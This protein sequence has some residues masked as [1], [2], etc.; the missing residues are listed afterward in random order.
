M[1]VDTR[2]RAR[3]ARGLRVGTWVPVGPVRAEPVV[4]AGARLHGVALSAQRRVAL[5]AQTCFRTVDRGGTRDTGGW[6]RLNRQGSAALSAEGLDEARELA[7]QARVRGVGVTGPNGLSKGVA[8]PLLEASPD[9]EM[10]GGLDYDE[11]PWKAATVATGTGTGPL[12]CDP[13]P[14]A[15]SRS[16]SCGIGRLARAGDRGQ[17][18]TSTEPR[19]G[20]VLV[21]QGADHR[22]MVTS[23]S[24]LVE[25]GEA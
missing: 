4:A 9:E 22:R 6:V 19:G 17:A 16:T 25:V 20:A 3:I 10:S 1:A 12:P 2:G 5:T 24:E 23:G 8:K 11:M 7:R 15:R 13:R 14:A 18:A 21:R